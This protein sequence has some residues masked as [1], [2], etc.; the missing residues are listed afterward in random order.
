MSVTISNDYVSMINK[1]GSGYNIPVIVDAIVDAAIAPVKELVT[2][3]KEKVDASISGM[4]TLKSSMG[5]SQAVINSLN[6]TSHN[7][8]SVKP[9]SNYISAAI[10]D[11]SKVK[12]GTY[13]VTNIIPAK[14]M[15]FLMTNVGAKTAT[16]DD[17]TITIHFGKNT[18]TDN[19][20]ADNPARS[21]TVE[22]SDLTMDEVVEKLNAVDGLAVE[23]TTIDTD[24]SKNSIVFTSKFGEFN[25][26]QMESTLSTGFKTATN[27]SYNGE[28]KLASA[29]GSFMLDNVV[30]TRENNS[31]S[32]A[33]PGVTIDLLVYRTNLQT[34]TVTKSSENIQKTVESLIAELNAYKADLNALG[35]VDE[36]G[37][38]DGQ[39]ANNSFLQNA[40]QKFLKLMTDP[41]SGYGDSAIYFVEFGIKTAADGSYT[42]DKTTF[43]R[44]YAKAP[45]KFY[46]LT[47]DKAYASNPNIDVY[48]G[49]TGIP[50]GKHTFAGTGN[51][52]S[53]ELSNTQKTLFSAASGSKFSFTTTD[54]PGFLMQADNN[55]PG[56]LSIYIGRSAKTKLNNFFA[57]ALASN[58]NHD[59]VVALY[60]EQSVNLDA[61]LDKIDQRELLLQSRYTKEFSAMEKVVTNSSSSEDFI[62]QMVDSWNK[63]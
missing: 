11:D 56:D 52:L 4:A 12:V 36:L 10:T 7:A 51:I 26:F 19:F 5:T 30:Y 60:K 38:E 28:I 62:T 17:Q 14:P 40:K 15:T 2:A 33:I 21:V 31:V 34:L 44:T 50:A 18:L 45:D 23:F 27:N 6:S 63:S 59:A 48:P 25:G 20:V 54:Y 3:K 58:G 47:E 61:R 8:I 37:D 1:K 29:D 53:H 9:N 42:F 55:T 57:D 13:R 24:T 46:A 22:I 35:F 39:L 49:S 43:D 16:V 32:D 41:I